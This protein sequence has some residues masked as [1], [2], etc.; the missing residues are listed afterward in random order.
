[1]FVDAAETISD[2]VYS[3]VDISGELFP[4]VTDLIKWEGHGSS[5]GSSDIVDS[6]ESFTGEFNGSNVTIQG[7]VAIEDEFTSGDSGGT[8]YEDVS[9]GTPK[10]A[11]IIMGNEDNDGYYVPYY[12]ITNAFSGLTFTY[13]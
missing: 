4:V 8:V 2:K 9:S 10:F 3:N 5:G 6:Y 13:T 1:M 12:R 11:G 7:A